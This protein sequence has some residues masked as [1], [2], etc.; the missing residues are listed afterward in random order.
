MQS[1]DS[2]TQ[3]VQLVFG[4]MAAEVLFTAARLGIADR[5]GDAERTGSDVAGDIGADPT[6]V[7]RL[8]RTMA[9][10]GI[11]T[12]TAPGRFSLT[13]AGALLRS[14]RPDSMHSFVEM[15]GDPAMLAAW[16]ELGH[17]V[18]T[19]ETTFD[20]VFGTSFFGYLADR[21]ELSARFNAAMR[22]GTAATAQQLPDAYDFGKYRTV[23]DIG[24][25]DGTLLTAV[26]AANPHLHG[27]LF[28]TAEGLAQADATF[29]AAG[30]ADRCQTVVGDFFRAAPEG[31]DLYTIKSVLHDWDDDRCRTILAHMRNVI[32]AHGRLLII[33]PVLP[34]TV[35]GTLPPQM[36]LSDL[37][38]LVNVG[39]RERT[40]ADFEELCADAGFRLT[41]V[42]PLP[43]PAAFSL[44]EAEPV[45]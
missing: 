33:E 31:A 34:P 14:D 9:A 23:A 18:H 1:A 26:L 7:T 19:G 39:G 37:N 12:E 2:R 42:T 13:E 25:G 15:F 16:R 4:A 36:Y 17:A 35:D 21:P 30:V 20:R 27:I 3:I 28:D 29:T 38:M 45:S 43:P 40:R 5:M 8:L 44:L 22:Q 32:P 10:L 6:S 24:G 11:L 41:T